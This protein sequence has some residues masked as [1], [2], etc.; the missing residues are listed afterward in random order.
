MKNHESGNALCVY[1]MIL[2]APNPKRG[3]ALK[4]RTRAPSSLSCCL[5][6]LVA[7]RSIYIH[8]G[9]ALETPNHTTTTTSMHACMHACMHAVLM[10]GSND[11]HLNN[12]G[13][14][15]VSHS[16]GIPKITIRQ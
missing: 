15:Q 9:R 6:L 2:S 5:L 16:K 8:G 3:D 4:R 1:I 14:L 10:K 12:L 11:I 7:I 13:S